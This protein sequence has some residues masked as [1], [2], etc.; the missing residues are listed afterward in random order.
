MIKL[1]VVI[2]TFNEEK[3]IVRCLD[4]VKEVADE[5]I[6]VDSFSTDK[7]G[8][9]CTEKGARFVRHPWP[10]YGAQ[11]NYGNSLASN[12]WI[13]SLDADE[14][15]SLKL[16]ESIARVK[17]NPAYRAYAMN[18]LTNYCGHWIRHCGWYPDTKIRLFDRR[19]A[20]WDLELVHENLL[21]DEGTA[22][23]F[24][25]GDLLHYSFLS[26]EDH[27]RQVEHYSGL[28]A[29]QFFEKGRKAGLLKIWFS[30][31]AR[32]IR[33]YFFRLGF[34]DGTAGFSVCSLSARAA[35]LKYRKLRKL[36]HERKNHPLY[37]S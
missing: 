15:L 9:I 18:R 35:F 31:P 28:V 5:I 19:S 11:K 7:T 14:A 24:L 20:R 16:G 3:N 17:E 10:G 22:S 13:L 30:G 34:L 33:D 36:H 8:E 23:G 29:R 26:R 1:S 21:I 37:H 6:V 25:Q 32:F 27:L 2:I 4:S 12:D